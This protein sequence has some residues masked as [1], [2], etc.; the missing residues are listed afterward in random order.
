M[1]SHETLNDLPA[2]AI[3]VLISGR[4]Q[5]VGFRYS[6]QQKARELGVSGWVRNRRDG[7]V[8]AVFEGAPTSVQTAIAWCHHGPAMAE[9]N[10]VETFREA[11]QD[12]CQFDIWPTT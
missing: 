12:L 9:V 4:V 6:T 10:H 7:S 8:E 5:G 11:T 2:T 1:T 3:R